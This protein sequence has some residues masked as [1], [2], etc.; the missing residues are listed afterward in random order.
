M[1][2]V[3]LISQSAYLP[4]VE[5]LSILVT[6]WVVQGLAESK[7][8]TVVKGDSRSHVI[9]AASILAKVISCNLPKQD[10]NA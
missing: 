8:R 3:D 7:C 5:N 10:T 2:E 4:S 1:N 9:A 6:S